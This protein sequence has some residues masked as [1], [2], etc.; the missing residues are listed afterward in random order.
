MCGS[1]RWHGCAKAE[2][3][4][5]RGDGQGNMEMDIVR[6]EMDTISVESS[7]WMCPVVKGYSFDGKMSCCIRVEK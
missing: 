4:G 6:M 5:K 3:E 1:L 2:T 7:G